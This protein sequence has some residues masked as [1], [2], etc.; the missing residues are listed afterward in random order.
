M[1]TSRFCAVIGVPERTWRRR[2]ARARAGWP[3]GPWPRPVTAVMVFCPV[4]VT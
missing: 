1:P 2:Q 3:K 4:A